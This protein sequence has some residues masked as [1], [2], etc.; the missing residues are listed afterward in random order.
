MRLILIISYTLLQILLPSD[1]QRNW[2]IVNSYPIPEGAS[3]LA[4]DG[5]YLYC[6]IYGVDGDKVY[7]INPFNGDYELYFNSTVLEDSFGLTYDNEFIWS[8]KQVGFSEPA[9]AVKLDSSGNQLGSIILPDH[10]MSGIAFDNNNFWVATY[11]P[12]PGTIYQINQNGDIINQIFS[13]DEQPWDISLGNSG[14]W[15]VDYWG[16]AIY[17]VDKTNGTVINTYSTEGVDPSGI[18][19][20]GNYLW[21]CDNGPNYD[22]DYLYQVN[23]Y[24][25][26]TPEIYTNTEN[27]N[28]GNVGISL[29]DE[30]V[31]NISNV[32]DGDLILDHYDITNNAF[33]LDTSFPIT[34][35]SGGDIDITLTFSPSD[36]GVYSGILKLYSNDPL[37]SISFIQLNGYGMENEQEILLEYIDLNLGD[38]RINSHTSRSLQIYNV[39]SE[40][41]IIDNINFSSDVF[42]VDNSIVFPFTI[43]PLDN[44]DIRYW[45]NSDIY[46]LYSETMN[47]ASNDSDEN[48]SVVNLNA[49]VIA[50]DTTIGT[51]L[52][53]FQSNNNQDKISAIMPFI[54]LNDDNVQEILVAD[55]NYSLFCLNGNSSGVADIIWKLN[56]YIPLIG[57]GSIYDEK[58]LTIIDD[59]NSDGIQ[60]IVI[61]T[62]WGSRSVFAISGIDGSIVWHYDTDEY[63]DGGWVYEV[64]TQNDFNNDGIN[65]VLAASGDDGTDTGPRRVHLLNGINGDK[66][67]EHAFYVAMTAVISLDDINGDNIPDVVCSSSPDYTDGNIYVLD[68]SNG[69]IID[70]INTNSMAIFGLCS[71]NDFNNDGLMD[72]AYGDFNGNIKLISS[73]ND[74]VE[75]FS[76]QNGLIT[77]MESV[78]AYNQ[79]SYIL[80][81]TLN[82]YFPLINASD[83]NISWSASTSGNILDASP[84]NDLNGDLFFDILIGTLDD[85]LILFSGADGNQIFNKNMYSPVDQT[86]HIEDLDNNG[87][88]EIL[89]G[90]RNGNIFCYSGGEN[91]TT[92]LEGDVNFDNIVNILD[93]IIVVNI[94]LGL[95]LYSDLADFNNDQ[96]INILDV[97]QLV[98]IVLNL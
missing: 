27:I 90:L 22:I 9:L 30:Y 50:F 63:G 33:S 81:G 66:L 57:S 20:D 56:L 40:D 73:P 70:Q 29:T 47:I 4:F 75:T 18:V 88:Q 55:D 62:V 24:G 64:D 7:Q 25:S 86:S 11:Y 12:D 16:D 84:I 38:I 65:D 78:V 44:I 19:W 17:E 35:V 87:S 93:I 34:L 46:G 23:L 92:F 51:E 41:L 14:L 79:K 80:S 71:I 45:F 69:N 54:D 72:Y 82:N 67:W 91:S 21:Y 58:G 32:G 26:G 36:I 85:E 39:G 60:D 15:I 10:Y 76:T 61:G 94:V 1:I 48:I 49:N 28:F 74:V 37:N 5:E 95:S 97:I 89:V 8:I 13:P 59:I 68:G 83:G 53:N 3:G 42:Y 52:W 6:G 98:N 77:H 43:T 31:L 2:T 96:I